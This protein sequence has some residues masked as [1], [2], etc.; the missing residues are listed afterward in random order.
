MW[1]KILHANENFMKIFGIFLGPFFAH[2]EIQAH[3]ACGCV[4]RG[5]K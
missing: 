4:K 5:Y 3:L 2:V 1:S